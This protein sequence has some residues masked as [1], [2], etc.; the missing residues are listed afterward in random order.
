MLSEI[1]Q[2]Y[3]LSKSV[4][5]SVDCSFVNSLYDMRN[6]NERIEINKEFY[7]ERLN[8]PLL[9]KYF[10]LRVLD[11]I[12]PRELSDE[13][14]D[15]LVDTVSC[16]QNN[17]RLVDESMSNLTRI[18]GFV[19]VANLLIDLIEDNFDHEYL[20]FTYLR[21]LRSSEKHDS[22]DV[23]LKKLRSVYSFYWKDKQFMKRTN[24]SADVQQIYAQTVEVNIRYG[25]IIKTILS[26]FSNNSIREEASYHVIFDQ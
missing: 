13:F 16:I 25:K 8:G 17:L 22:Y 14:L 26:S 19:A 24:R 18:Y 23:R 4:S 5:Y 2:K 10:A 15:K 20:V 6:F 12:G 7:L 3:V 1:Y 21:L 11:I 9:D